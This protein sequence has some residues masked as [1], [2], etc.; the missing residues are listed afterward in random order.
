MKLFPYLIASLI[1]V[2]GSYFTY[3][4]YSSHNQINTLNKEKVLSLNS[5]SDKQVKN[6]ENKN[7]L[8]T[9]K[10]STNQS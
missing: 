9:N 7:S 8:D 5:S 6:S 1:L 10:T 3:T 4:I 2:A